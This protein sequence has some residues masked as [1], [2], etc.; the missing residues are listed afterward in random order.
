VRGWG[1]N[2][3]YAFPLL[4][5]Y[6]ARMSLPP[7]FPPARPERR[8]VRGILLVFGLVVLCVAS[9]L[10]VLAYR[11]AQPRWYFAQAV[12]DVPPPR[13][14]RPHDGFA[15]SQAQLLRTSDVLERVVNMLDLAK[16]YAADGARV[17]PEE[18]RNALGQSLRIEASAGEPQR[19][20]IG[21][22]AADPNLAANIANL[23]AVVYRNSR[24]EASQQHLERSLSQYSDEVQKQRTVV[25][26]AEKE[27]RQIRERDQIIDPDLERPD[28]PEAA[29]TAYTEAKV[30]YLQAKRILESAE[31]ALSKARMEHQ[32]D[33][34]PIRIVQRGVPP[35]RPMPWWRGD[36]RPLTERP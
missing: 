16:I 26:A 14:G 33:D 6:G 31:L 17:T 36:P 22:Y 30:K 32:V 3:R 34:D 2:I 21:A 15:V 10:G 1:R 5:D 27:L 24:I 28:S 25:Q 19:I 8:G 23:V 12:I 35:A 7:A 4:S 13:D 29:P 9:A 18:A 20:Y 11:F